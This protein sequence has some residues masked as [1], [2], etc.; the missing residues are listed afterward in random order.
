MYFEKYINANT[1]Q[2]T[3]VKKLLNHLENLQKNLMVKEKN[4]K[5][6]GFSTAARTHFLTTVFQDN[7]NKLVALNAFFKLI[8]LNAL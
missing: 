1:G 8:S 6:T 7:H 2:V 3:R 5:N 4:P